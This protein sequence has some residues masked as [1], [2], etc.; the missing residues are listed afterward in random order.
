MD[1][2]YNSYTILITTWGRLEPNGF[3]PEV[4]ITNKFPNFLQTIKIN[5]T[6]STKDAAER[7]ALKVAQ[8]WV[9]NHPAHSEV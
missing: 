8:R 4:R 9:D 1:W 5:E 3:R 6:F 7:Y 2:L